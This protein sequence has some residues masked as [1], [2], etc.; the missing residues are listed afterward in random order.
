MGKHTGA[1]STVSGPRIEGSRWIVNVKRI[2]WDV[3]EL[4]NNKL[5]DGGRHEGMAELI[6]KAFADSLEVL[7]NEDI[8][9]I[10]SMHSD[11]ARF[12]TEYLE[13]KPRWLQ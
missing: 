7:V 11:F 13:G 5:E 3:V 4:L 8:L 10:Y 9:K 12:L 2:Y 1:D 6:S